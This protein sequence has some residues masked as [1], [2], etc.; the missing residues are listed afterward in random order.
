MNG[1]RISVANVTSRKS[2]PTFCTHLPST[3]PRRDAAMIVIIKSDA[4]ADR[5]QFALVHP[6]GARSDRVGNVLLDDQADAGHHRDAK[7]PKV[8]GHH[9]RDEIVER[10]LGPLIDATLERR[11]AIQKDHDR[12]QRQIEGDDRQHPIRHLMASEL[13][14]PANPDCA[15]DKNDLRQDE[16]EQ[17]EFLFQRRAARFDLVF[18]GG[19]ICLICRVVP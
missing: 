19:E 8:P 14:R 6:R 15:D 17:A 16:I 3:R 7:D 12:R 4:D 1:S 2:P 18:D 5:H 10:D 11:E 9:E 13:R